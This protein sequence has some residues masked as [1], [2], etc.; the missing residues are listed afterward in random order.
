MTAKDKKQIQVKP[1]SQNQ[2][3]VRWGYGL[4]AALI[5]L[6]LIVFSIALGQVLHSAT[7]GLHKVSFPGE[8]RLTLEPGVHMGIYVPEGE[9]LPPEKLADLSVALRDGNGSTLESPPT[10]WY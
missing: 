2:A 4:G 9:P 6:G 1:T 7:R 8:Q 3:L 10:W 5:L